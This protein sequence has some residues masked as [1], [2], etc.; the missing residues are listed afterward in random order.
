MQLFYFDMTVFDCQMSNVD[1]ILKIQAPQ[2]TSKEAE[3]AS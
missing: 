2:E 3:A 1:M